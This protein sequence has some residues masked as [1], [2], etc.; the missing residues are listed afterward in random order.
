MHHW[1][2]NA[3]LFSSLFSEDWGFAEECRR[4][5]RVAKA[6]GDFNWSA[7]DDAGEEAYSQATGH[8]VSVREYR[9]CFAAWA[10]TS[11]EGESDLDP[12]ALVDWL[13]SVQ[14]FEKDARS[15]VCAF[16]EGA[17]QPLQHWVGGWLALPSW[18]MCLCGVC[19]L[20]FLD[21]TS[22]LLRGKVGRP[23]FPRICHVRS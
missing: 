17:L 23:R 2:Q 21:Y 6:I 11:L 5:L 9:A 22:A 8:L 3:A 14:G 12:E 15:K 19:L 4:A 1:H 18:G 16:V 10:R 20:A 7:L 13:E